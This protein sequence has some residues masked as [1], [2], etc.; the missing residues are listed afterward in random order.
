M[1][2][3]S[4]LHSSTSL[5]LEISRKPKFTESYKAWCDPVPVRYS[6]EETDLFCVS[7]IKH[8]STVMQSVD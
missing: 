8:G 7:G 2:V 1:V 5:R 3:S 6:D 4:Q